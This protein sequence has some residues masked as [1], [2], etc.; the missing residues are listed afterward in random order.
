MLNRIARKTDELSGLTLLDHKFIQVIVEKL[1]WARKIIAHL[2][3]HLLLRASSLKY[4]KVL[5]INSCVSL[6]LLSHEKKAEIP[7]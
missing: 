6:K 4:S 3:F 5:L 7:L 2:R 1:R